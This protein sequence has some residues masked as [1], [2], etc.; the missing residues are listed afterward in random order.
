MSTTGGASHRAS[1]S[2]PRTLS[3][4]ANR[5]PHRQ[6]FVDGVESRGTC[7][8]YRAATKPTCRNMPRTLETGPGHFA[9]QLP[10]VLSV[11]SVVNSFCKPLR[12]LRLGGE[13]DH[14]SKLPS[15]RLSK[16]SPNPIK[17]NKITTKKSWHRIS[18][19]SLSGNSPEKKK[20]PTPGN[21]G[22]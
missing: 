16:I 6:V 21:N 22:E 20:H 15:V 18:R 8:F 5:G 11:P 17:S 10:S 14:S 19:I 7:G 4:R 2:N 12:P 13:T 1:G 3:S 9:T